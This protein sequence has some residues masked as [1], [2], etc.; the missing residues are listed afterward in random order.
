[1]AQGA[2]AQAH[3]EPMRNHRLAG[4]RAPAYWVSLYHKCLWLV[5][6]SF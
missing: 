5:L 4:K 1:M 2:R 3:Q 6:F